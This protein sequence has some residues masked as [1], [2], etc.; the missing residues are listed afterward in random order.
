MVTFGNILRTTR[1][2]GIIRGDGVEKTR[3]AVRVLFDSGVRLVEVSLTGPGALEAISSVE[4]PDGCWLG[5][6]TVRTA[7][8]AS[9]AI[10]AGATFAV[11]PALSASAAACVEAGLPLLAGALTPTEIETALSLGVEAVKLFPAS[12][13]GPAYLSALRQPFPDVPFVPVGGVGL[14][15]AEA[16]LAAG[17]IAVGVGSPLVG[18]AA[19]GG[20]LS[21]LA[22]RAAR[23][24]KLASS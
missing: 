15:E 7:A 3:D 9:A 14:A 21:A 5:A 10:A 19:S 11:S 6:G 24:V 8:Q 13:G 16:Y 17:A 23:F 18:D 4:A 22:E 1:L 2:V 12:I 20:D